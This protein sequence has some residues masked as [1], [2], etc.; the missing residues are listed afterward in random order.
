M[1]IRDRVWLADRG[2]EWWNDNL[3]A[4]HGHLVAFG[5]LTYTALEEGATVT[6]TGDTATVTV[7]GVDAALDAGDVR[8]FYRVLDGADTAH[9]A[10]YRIHDVLCRVSGTTLTITGHKSYF[11]TPAILDADTPADYDDS[12][13]YVA[14]VDVYQEAVDAEL[15]ITFVWD[16]VAENLSGDPTADLTQTGAA[17]IVDAASGVFRARVATYAGGVHDFDYPDYT[18]APLYL[19]ADY[20]AGYALADEARGQ[21]DARLEVAVV[22]LANTLSPDYRHALN[23]LAESKWR[24]DRAMPTE[25]NPLRPDELENP[26][27]YTNG[28]RLAWDVVRQMRNHPLPF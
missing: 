1:C 15:P 5:T 2:A 20:V 24:S 25:D 8:V 27:G 10:G 12:A 18:R 4:P 23:D 14:A 16:T 26:F 17:L 13:S 28:A 6:I 22:R 11:A 9:S 7:T 19:K 21:M 3:T